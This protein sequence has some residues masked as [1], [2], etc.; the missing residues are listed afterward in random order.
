MV[1]SN[2]PG[3]AHVPS[4]AAVCG[5]F[6]SACTFYIGTREDPARLDRMAATLRVS[7]EVLHCDGCRSDRRIFYCENCVMSGCARDK[8]Y[9]F[10]GEC[11]ECPCSELEQFVA[12]RPHRADILRDLGRIRDV[13][14]AAWI[15][16]ARQ[17]HSCPECGTLNSAY[18]LLCRSCGRD[19]SS[20]YVEEHRDAVIARLRQDAAR[21]E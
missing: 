18:D 6:C 8:G 4:V 3:L 7:K 13:G 19:P 2:D 14:A 15:G 16:E 10:C 21:R 5:L 12:E 9:D 17:R 20:P 11:P 1:A